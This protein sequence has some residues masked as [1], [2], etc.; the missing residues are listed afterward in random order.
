VLIGG[1]DTDDTIRAW[2]FELEVGVVRDHHEPGVAGAPKNGVVCPIES[3]HLE[4]ESFLPK[5]GG[6]TNT[7]LEV[8]PCDSQ[9]VEGLGH[10]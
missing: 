2:H 10:K 4:S 7:G 1:P 5:V 6:S 9:K 3:N 8:R